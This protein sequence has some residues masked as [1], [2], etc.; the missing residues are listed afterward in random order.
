[1]LNQYE[2]VFFHSCFT[3]AFAET[4]TTR[5]APFPLFISVAQHIEVKDLPKRITAYISKLLRPAA[6]AFLKFSITVVW[7]G[8]GG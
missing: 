6:V 3:S 1:M 8:R 4:T 7:L 5:F 2:T